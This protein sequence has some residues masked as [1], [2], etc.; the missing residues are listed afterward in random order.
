MADM[1]ELPDFGT[2]RIICIGDLMLDRFVD[3]TVERIS[4]E[5]PVPILRLGVTRSVP[6]GAANVARNIVALGGHCSLIGAIGC[7]PVGKELIALVETD[8]RIALHAAH[9]SSRPTTE[10]TRFTAQGQ[11]LLR[12][13][14][15]RNDPIDD[16][17]LDG[18]INRVTAQIGQHDVVILSDYAKGVVDDRLAR[19]VIA[20][21]RK[22]GVPVIADPKTIHFDRYR[23]AAAITP[24]VAEA[25]S[26]TGVRATDDETAAAAIRAIADRFGIDGVLLTRAEQGMSLLNDG[27]T[28]VHIA[29]SAR[30]VFDVVGAGD[31][32]AAVLA[33]GLGSGLDLE[34]SARIA[35]AA[36]GIVVAK[37]GTAT[38][39]R[40]EL[41]DELTRTRSAGLTSAARILDRAK[42][43]ALRAEWKADGLSVGFTNGCFD[44]LHAGHVQ[45]LQFARSRCDRLIVG[46]N[47]DASVARLKGPSR[48]IVGLG[49][50]AEVL[51]AL[52]AVDA[53]VAFAEDTP[54]DLITALRPDMLVKG[55]DYTVEQIVGADIVLANGGRIERFD[56]VQGRSTTGIVARAAGLVDIGAS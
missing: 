46:L 45:L 6:G 56:L 48:P 17:V 14:R 27:S 40:G 39:S 21:A 24:N 44:I 52:A 4:P 15:E 5:S 32:V 12:V 42:A 2:V 22:A 1:D 8:G 33:L 23:G 18:I 43:E 26:A 19:S 38:V 31:T 47:D 16:A 7:D 3:G 28:V 9:D 53:V 10:K 13:D 50:R 41:L 49:D 36:A 34:T 20:I 30:D 55:S 25:A 54:Y 51:A 37:Q 29:A 35:N 11:H